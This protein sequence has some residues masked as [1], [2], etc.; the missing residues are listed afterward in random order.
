MDKIREGVLVSGVIMCLLFLITFTSRS[1]SV[2]DGSVANGFSGGNGTVGSPFL[3]ADGSQLALLAANVNKGNEYNGTYFKLTKDV[4]LGGKINWMPIGMNVDNQF[5]GKFDGGSMLITNLYVDRVDLES[6]G[7]FGFIGAGSEVHHLG[8]VGTSNIIGGKNVGS[9]AGRSSGSINNCYA[10]ANVVANQGS[11]TVEVGVGGIVGFNNGTVSACYSVGRVVGNIT[12]GI[13]GWDWTTSDDNI[14]DCFFD[15]QVC[16]IT[17]AVGNKKNTNNR[18]GRNTA[19]MT[20]GLQWSLGFTKANWYLHYGLYPQFAGREGADWSKVAASPVFLAGG[21]SVD[22][23]RNSFAVSVL[24]GCVWSVDSQSFNS[25]VID[26]GSA[27][28]TRPSAK[29]D[30]V[31]LV[32][33]LNS[34][35][36]M[37]R[38]II[39]KTKSNIIL[40]I[41]GNGTVTYDGSVMLDGDYITIEEGMVSPTL[42]FKPKDTSY[43]ALLKFGKDD[44]RPLADYDNSSLYYTTPSIQF[45]TELKVVFEK[46]KAWKGDATEPFKSSDGNKILIYRA[47]ELAHI[48]QNVTQKSDFT[49][50]SLKL[51]NSLD[52]GGNAMEN[53][54][55]WTPIG[56]PDGQNNISQFNGF[57]D[58]G[59]NKIYNIYCYLTSKYYVGLFGIVGSSGQIKNTI[60]ENGD[61]S[62]LGWVGG[63]AGENRGSITYCFNGSNISSADKNAG[64]LV[65]FNNGGVIEN[66]NNKGDIKGRTEVGGVVGYNYNADI[67]NCSNSGYIN[68]T[69][70]ST[71]GIVGRDNSPNRTIYKC[72]NTGKI[73]GR[74]CT[75]GVVGKNM[76]AIVSWCFNKGAIE[77]NASVGGL[78]GELSGG[79]LNIS[80]NMGEV[81]GKDKTGG[82]V[83]DNYAC[84]ID[85]CFNKG[86]VAGTTNT[87]GITG[88]NEG[89]VANCYNMSEVSGTNFV[90]GIS[91]KSLKNSEMQY[92]YN[93]GCV[94]GNENIGA[95]TGSNSDE[96]F[97][98]NYCRYDKELCSTFEACGNGDVP[99]KAIGINSEE[100]KEIYELFNSMQPSNIWKPD[101]GNND[102]YPVLYWQSV[103]GVQTAIGGA[104]K[105]YPNPTR[106]IV[107]IEGKNIVNVMICNLAGQVIKTFTNY[108]L[109]D[110]VVVN[111]GDLKSGIYLLSVINSNGASNTKKIVKQ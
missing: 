40:S 42:T 75:G 14:K 65:G 101:I 106:G 46:C 80:Y 24:N 13:C 15:N 34:V 89:V 18:E 110:K 81:I 83:G 96:P 87:G 5:R 54:P 105:M 78:V 47:E 30:T 85:A 1:Q 11:A 20:T 22:V 98:M 41:S 73:G 19:D 92:V 53:K 63:I 25:V 45:D 107:N 100:L 3:I 38:V 69:I 29:N 97:V 32:C 79:V 21:E 44:V 93:T 70:I 59:Y 84:F 67:K 76:G 82:L 103:D 43:L 55:V 17:R 72:M 26:G 27:V 37:F 31:M 6:V 39:Q 86:T 77:G 108:D 99:E 7:L 111:L 8:I 50:V 68:G 62:G 71:G 48:A 58:G 90:G 9:I 74:D 10:M 23:V 102:G 35:S 49:G 51:V 104:Y 56:M 60:V 33:S 28:V 2:W 12:G 4:D 88:Y 52:L 66:C 57:F 109:S 16:P 94:T 36:K 95:I 64:G 61:I 91:G